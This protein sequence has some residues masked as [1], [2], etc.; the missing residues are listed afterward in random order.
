VRIL[1][2]EQNA[3]T[4]GRKR[5]LSWTPT[6]GGKGKK[7]RIA[8]ETPLPGQRRRLPTPPPSGYQVNGIKVKARACGGRYHSMEMASVGHWA[9]HD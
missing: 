7:N 6:R 9:S 1:R 2:D 3:V 8:S 5:R 4:E